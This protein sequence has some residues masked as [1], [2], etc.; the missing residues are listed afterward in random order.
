M[1]KYFCLLLSLPFLISGCETDI[2]RSERLSAEKSERDAI[3]A[4]G[5]V[6][7]YH[8]GFDEGL[9]KF[10]NEFDEE[11]APNYD[12]LQ[13]TVLFY[14]QNVCIIDDVHNKYHAYNECWDLMDTDSTTLMFIDNAEAEGYVKC[15][16]CYQDME[17]YPM[18]SYDE[19]TDDYKPEN[20]PSKDWIEYPTE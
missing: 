4:E 19:L 7:G 11:I 3:Y 13:Q 10:R 14:A 16:K 8:E 15:S 6:K 2:D 17:Y 1:K 12:W 5:Y 9:K 20:C 18:P